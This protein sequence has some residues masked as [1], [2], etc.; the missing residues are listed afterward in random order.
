MKIKVKKVLYLTYEGLVRSLYVSKNKNAKKFANWASKVL[1]TVQMGTKEQKDDLVSKVLGVSARAVKEVFKTSS[2]TIPC[3]YLFSLNTV[4][5]L[6]KKMN[7]HKKYSDDSIVCKYGFTKD[8]SRRTRE[9][10]KEYGKFEKVNLKLK[11]HSYI[12]PQYISKAEAD[13]KDFFEALDVTLTYE[14]YDELVIVKP[15]LLR[16]I[17]RQ[18]R[19]LSNAYAGHIKELIKRVEDL[20]K[21]MELKEEKHK[22]EMLV[23]DNKINM[24]KKENEMLEKDLEIERMRNELLQTKIIK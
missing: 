17:D 1:F 23:K 24:L 8:L 3:V 21:E 5:N 4:E 20:K 13:I 16:T 19:Q 7:I 18:Y 12:D 11:H 9:H 15:S 14:D 10:L 2:T 22:N 6:R